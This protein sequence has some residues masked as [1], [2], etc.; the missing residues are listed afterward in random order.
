MTPADPAL[1]QAAAQATSAL[2]AK[3]GAPQ[4]ARIERGVAQVL[5]AWRPSDGDG[6][7]LAAL[8]EAQFVAD[9]GGLDALLARFEQTLEALDGGF[10]EQNRTLSSWAVL[11]QGPMQ[12]VDQLLQAFD[13]GAPTSSTT[14]ST[15]SSPSSPL[16]NFPLTTLEERLRDGDALVA[17]PVG[18]GAPDR[19]LRRGACPADVNQQLAPRP[20]PRPSSTSPTT[21]S[22]CTTCSTTTG[23]RLFPQ[24]MRLISH[25]NLRDELKADYADEGRPRRASALIQQGDGA[26]RHPDD[27]G[28]G[29]RQ[30]AASTGTRSRTR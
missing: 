13:A 11:D 23:E 18:G 10:V 25:W 28:G 4:R 12:P 20:P 9:P 2:V 29:H 30:P 21:T 15:R 24:G 22:G 26:H 7:A 19:A 16:L 6:K 5:A 17:P 27:P 14:C 3:H 8:L 1:A